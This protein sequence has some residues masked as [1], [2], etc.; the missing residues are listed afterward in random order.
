[1]KKEAKKDLEEYYNENYQFTN[2]TFNKYYD[3]T[4][5]KNCTFTKC[6]FENATFQ[7]IDFENSN[8][9]ECNLSIQEFNSR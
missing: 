2:I 9:T 7:G 3:Y 5:I 8:L 1:M 6:S 4:E